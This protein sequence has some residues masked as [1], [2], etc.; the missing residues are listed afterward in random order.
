MPSNGVVW[1]EENGKTAK[2]KTAK[3]NYV[4]AGLK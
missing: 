3:L 1:P 2:G 4:A